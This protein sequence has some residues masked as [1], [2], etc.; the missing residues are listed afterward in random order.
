[1]FYVEYPHLLCYANLMF[2]PYRRDLISKSFFRFSEILFGA[3]AVY[4][5]FGER[6]WILKL[7]V[8]VSTVL[9]FIFAVAIS[10]DRSPE[11]GK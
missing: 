6:P 8:L 7:A 5:W 3:G 10:P 1:M 2:G 11:R 4:I 9:L